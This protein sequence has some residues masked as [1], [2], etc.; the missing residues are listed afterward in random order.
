MCSNWFP[1][2]II[3]IYHIGW[4]R[5]FIQYEGIQQFYFIC[6]A[7]SHRNGKRIVEA[8]LRNENN[9]DMDNTW[10]IL[11]NKEVNT[12]CMELIDEKRALIRVKSVE[13]GY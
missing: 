2:T 11:E 5:I 6:R 1:P 3:K 4:K 8:S 9:E 10:S 7:I 13:N 12:K